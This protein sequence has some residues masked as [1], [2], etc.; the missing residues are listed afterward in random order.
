MTIARS[1]LDISILGEKRLNNVCFYEIKPFILLFQKKLIRALNCE[2][3]SVKHEEI[4]NDHLIIRLIVHIKGKSNQQIIYQKLQMVFG[5]LKIKINNYSIEVKE[6]K[7]GDPESHDLDNIELKANKIIKRKSI[8]NN[9]KKPIYI[10]NVNIYKYSPSY[11]YDNK[12]YNFKE[13]DNY[14]ELE[15]CY[16]RKEKIQTDKLKHDY[17]II[18]KVNKE[19]EDLTAGYINKTNGKN[20]FIAVVHVTPGAGKTY[21]SILYLVKY[22][23]SHIDLSLQYVDFIKE[24]FSNPKVNNI[25]LQEFATYLTSLVS[26]NFYFAFPTVDKVYE[27]YLELHTIFDKVIDTVSSIKKNKIKNIFFEITN[28][29][30]ST[31]NKYLYYIYRSNL[32]LYMSLLSYGLINE[33][34]YDKL[35][36][37]EFINIIS[38]ISN[39]L[40]VDKINL[41]KYSKAIHIG[42]NLNHKSLTINKFSKYICKILFAESLKCRKIYF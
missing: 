30:I 27:A 31:Q 33:Y 22:F 9:I 8:I 38:K 25:N 32:I 34:S 23:I 36:N 10:D 2:I 18:N 20:P 6:D 29:D 13:Y 11:F 37:K 5:N 3:I 41:I 12:N 4:S 1:N 14:E 17:S 28:L 35:K 16:H 21:N 40:D 7:L 26:K 19:V 42:N 39:Q 24:K 15:S